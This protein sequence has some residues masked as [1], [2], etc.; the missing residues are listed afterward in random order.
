MSDNSQYGLD[1]ALLSAYLDDELSA[2][3]RALVERRLADDPNARQTL[4]HLRNVSLAVRELPRQAVPQ[5]LRG[6]VLQKVQAAKASSRAAEAP[7]A[8]AEA[9][10]PMPKLTIGRTPRGWIWASLAVA[11]ALFIMFVQPNDDRNPPVGGV[12]QRTSEASKEKE[13]LERELPQLRA[14]NEPA[15]PESA[16]GPAVAAAPAPTPNERA[17]APAAGAPVSADHLSAP[18][19]APAAIELG[20]SAPADVAVSD[21]SGTED[22]AAGPESATTMADDEVVVVQ[23]VAKRSALQNK[24]FDK[25]LADN[26]IAVEPAAMLELNKGRPK[27]YR[28]QAESGRQDEQFG[29][30]LSAETFGCEAVL[31]EAP[32]SAIE[33]CMKELNQDAINY[34]SVSVGESETADIVS[35][36]EVAGGKK[37][38]TDLGKYSRGVVSEEYEEYKDAFTRD[39]AFYYQ[40]GADGQ[41]TR[42]Q[43][44]SG[45]R[46]GIAAVEQ[47]AARA[48]ERKSESDRG[49]ARRVQ[50]W[51]VEGRGQ[52]EPSDRSEALAGNEPQADALKQQAMLRQMKSTASADGENSLVLFLLCPTEDTAPSPAAADR[53]E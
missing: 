34:V 7:I 16:P 21:V 37:L 49:R 46:G 4:E 47:D 15:A 33:S 50:P 52:L 5:D 36:R 53:A 17:D 45:G 13:S 27:T 39:K 11:A 9:S 32:P 48:P 28:A 31:V 25:L 41:D 35:A 30:R 43:S 24:S 1:D 8:A 19:G 26:G 42:R 51:S 3:D 12:A 23:V 44:Y 40:F 10:A 2:E 20:A 18:E 38:A 6:A 14:W 22:I 29:K